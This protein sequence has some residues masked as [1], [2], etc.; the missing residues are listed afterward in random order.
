[1]CLIVG[2]ELHSDAVVTIV[3]TVSVWIFSGYSTFLQV[4]F[5]IGLAILVLVM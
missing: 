4:I 2:E 5:G 1:M 3:S